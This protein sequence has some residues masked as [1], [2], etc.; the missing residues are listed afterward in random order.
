MVR[1][2]VVIPCYNA[3]K[4]IA[5]C[6]D[7]VKAQTYTDWHCVIVDDCSTDNSAIIV[8]RETQGDDRFTFLHQETN[9]G[10]SA[11]R[12]IGIYNAKGGYILPLDADDR[13]MP[14][15]L[16]EFAAAAERDPNAALFIPRIRRFGDGI[17]EVVQERQWYGYEDLK[18]RCTP[19]NTSMFRWEA[20]MNVGG[21]RSGTMYEDWEFW[22]RLLY[23]ND[24]VVNINKVLVEY[25]VHDDSRWHDAVKYHDREVSIIRNMNPAIFGDKVLVVIPYLAKGAQ[26]NELELAITGWKKFFK[27]PHIIVVVGDNHP[28]LQQKGALFIDCPQVQPIPGQYLPHLDHVNKFRKVMETLPL[29]RGFIYTC[30]DI[31]PTSDFT[32]ADVL[33]PKYPERGFNFAVTDWHNQ[34]I[35]WYSDKLKTGA[36]CQREGLPVRNWICH[37]PVYYEWK[38]LLPIYDRY[39][40]DTNSY[41]VEN[42]YFNMMYPDDPHAVN[43]LEFRDEVRT[44]HPDT[45]PFNTIKWVTNANCGWSQ[46]LEDKLRRYY[47]GLDR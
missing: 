13:L 1:I 2:T 26:G 22:L 36:L 19:S 8:L 31:Y 46:E 38:N 16:K 25:R 37:L 10:V 20:W 11:A 41:I 28:C 12:N 34:P 4:Y 35:D 47:D 43:C 7:T 6:I 5:E 39:G 40:C 23:K 42:I 17:N 24:R 30:D 18:L 14:D 44:A 3:E 45:R 27:E 9:R 15:A 29:R 21:Y 32:M 33:M